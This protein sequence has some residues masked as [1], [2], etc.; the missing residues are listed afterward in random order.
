MKFATEINGKKIM[1]YFM[2]KKIVSERFS[3]LKDRTIHVLEIFMPILA[4]LIEKPPLDDEPSFIQRTMLPS[5]HL[6]RFV[7]FVDE[8]N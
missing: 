2:E 7:N 4:N 1:F 6:F 5:Q 8:L 3:L